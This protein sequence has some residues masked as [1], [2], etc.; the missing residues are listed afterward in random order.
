M[1]T[2]DTF[3][4]IILSIGNFVMAKFVQIIENVDELRHTIDEIY[5]KKYVSRRMFDIF[6]HNNGILSESWFA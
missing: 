3:R 4:Y 1:C 2:E 5:P 6:L